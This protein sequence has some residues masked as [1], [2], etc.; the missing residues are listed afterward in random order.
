MPR[1][2]TSTAR[3]AK[4]QLI[5]MTREAE[6]DSKIPTLSILSKKL[7][8]HPSTVFRILRDMAA[9]GI[10]WQS[11][12]GRF[13]PASGRA[14]QVKGLPVCFIGREIWQWSRLY[15][16]MLSGI[17]EVCSANG[18]SLVLL[19]VP[20]LIRQASP[21]QQPKFASPKTQKSE[22]EKRIPLIPR[23]CGGILFDHLWG[24]T[25]LALHRLMPPAPKV[26]LL[27]GTTKWMPVAA[28]N[29]EAAANLCRDF[30]SKNNLNHTI[31]V[32]PFANDSAIDFNIDVLTRALAPYHP[33][34][35]GFAE[36][37]G[38]IS[39]IAAKNPESRTCFVCPEDNTAKVLFEEIQ[40]SG[41]LKATVSL[42][43]TQGTGVLSAPAP[44]LRFDFRRLGRSAAAEVL[45]GQTS[46]PPSPSF[47]SN[48]AS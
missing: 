1:K 21:T 16:E 19:S 11:P 24:D 43:A 34:T 9:E 27:H 13:H 30:V 35:L 39:R 5:T 28:P 44:R 17:S 26:Q 38:N 41:K 20:S 10:V 47:V 37:L 14:Q 46:K 40:A 7:D 48:S 8:I 12:N 25:A 6:P 3:K 32:S 22:L 29:F 15:Q 36:A 33:V 45:L 2:P 23:N 18:S 42:F 4:E 31:L